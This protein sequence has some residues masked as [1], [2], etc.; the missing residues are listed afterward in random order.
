MDAKDGREAMKLAQEWVKRGGPPEPEQPKGLKVVVAKD[1]HT[2]YKQYKKAGMSTKEAMAQAT[3][4]MA[5]NLEAANAN[6]HAGH[7]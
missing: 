2:L 6:Q 7:A 3:A 5:A 1:F 4:E